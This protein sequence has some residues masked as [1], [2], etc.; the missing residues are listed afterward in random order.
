MSIMGA[1]YTDNT[2]Q[3]ESGDRVFFFTD[4][5]VELKN[6]QTGETFTVSDLKELLAENNEKSC[7]E[8]FGEIDK[9]I[10]NFSVNNGL[11]DDVTFLMLQVN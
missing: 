5:L 10:K 1:D 9:K 4:G 2:M 7:P 11:K 6:G 8:L 3:M